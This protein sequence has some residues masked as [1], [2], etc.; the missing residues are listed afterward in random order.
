MRSRWDVAIRVADK[1]VIKSSGQAPLLFAYPE[2]EVSQE[3]L[4]L[5]HVTFVLHFEKGE[6]NQS[7]RE[8]EDLCSHHTEGK[9]ARGSY[10]RQS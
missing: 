9:G 2:N 1:I 6:L 10:T 7:K 8:L 5:V 3:A 4:D